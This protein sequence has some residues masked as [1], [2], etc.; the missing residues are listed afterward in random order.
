MVVREREGERGRERE[1]QGPS[2]QHGLVTWSCL[3]TKAT[4]YTLNSGVPMLHGQATALLGKRHGE[5]WGPERDWRP[6]V[7]DKALILKST[8]YSGFDIVNV[9]GD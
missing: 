2:N 1:D 9:L 7:G 8:A 5:H 6:G 3:K 4:A